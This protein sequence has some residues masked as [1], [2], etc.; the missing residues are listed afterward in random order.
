VPV[1]S[2]SGEVLGALFFGLTNRPDYLHA[3]P[4]STP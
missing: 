3:R 2:R 4:H 1:L